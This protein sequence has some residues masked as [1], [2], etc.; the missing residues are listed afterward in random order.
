MNAAHGYEE[1]ELKDLIWIR[2]GKN[3]QTIRCQA[4]LVIAAYA[5]GCTSV[6][7]I[8]ELTGAGQSDRDYFPGC[9]ESEQEYL[10]GHVD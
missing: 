1:E 6:H 5:D 9:R 7:R 10:R 2:T 8:E 3:P 4:L